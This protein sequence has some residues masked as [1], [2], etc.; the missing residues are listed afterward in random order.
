MTQAIFP[1]PFRAIL[2]LFAFLFAARALAIPETA[3]TTPLQLDPSANDSRSPASTLEVIRLYAPSAAKKNPEGSLVSVS[4]PFALS[5]KDPAPERDYFLDIGTQHGLHSGDTVEVL[6]RVISN[7]I[8][9][10]GYLEMQ[11]KIADLR[12]IS[13]GQ[14]MAIARLVPTAANPDFPYQTYKKPMIGDAVRLKS[15]LPSPE[16]V[17]KISK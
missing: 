10:T 11:L 7:S 16:A 12:V 3:G 8:S 14:D 4:Y 13:I 15:E 2:F 17:S 6:R 9:G 1:I 5:S